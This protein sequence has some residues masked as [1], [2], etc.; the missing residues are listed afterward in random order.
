MKNIKK[1][2]RKKYHRSTDDVRYEKKNINY[3]A[4]MKNLL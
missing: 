2:L 1:K 4:W 3:T